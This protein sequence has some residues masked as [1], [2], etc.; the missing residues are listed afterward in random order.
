MFKTFIE[1][2]IFRHINETSLLVNQLTDKLVKA[3]PV[4]TGRILGEVFLHLIRSLEYYP[5]GLVQDVWEPLPY[6]IQNY[7]TADKIKQLYEKVETKVK[8]YL[9]QMTEKTLMERLNRFND[10][11][12]KAQI[13]LEMLEHSIQHR[14][15][16]LV[17]YRLL[18]IEPA[19]IPYI[20]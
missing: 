19:K 2:A 11:P 3:S 10:S 13:L 9:D 7:D 15:Q 17:Y 4:E 12:T 1:S 14:G 8:A 18:G 5:Q 20:V 6:N 16:I